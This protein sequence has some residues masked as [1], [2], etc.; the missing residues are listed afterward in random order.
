MNILAIDTSM[1]AC[2]VA[3]SARD[4]APRICA[5]YEKI[6]RGHA[7]RLPGMVDDVLKKAGLTIGQI[8]RFAVTRGPGTF[9][10]VRIGIAM[11]RGL[12]LGCNKPLVGI[13]TLQVLA[14][15]VLHKTPDLVSQKHQTDK[16]RLGIAIDA[17]RGEI[18][19]QRF[20]LSGEPLEEPL[21]LSPQTVADALKSGGDTVI[22]A[23][24]GAALITPLLGEM[25]LPP[26]LCPDL[27]PRA[28]RLVEIAARITASDIASPQS[29][30]PLYLRP[31]DAKVQTGH[32]IE[33]Q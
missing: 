28:E 22:L 2:S 27:Q 16:P 30:R 20:D 32:A 14:A 6:G 7:E 1:Q 17:R 18:Y 21:A 23:G 5:V 19:W 11:A 33:R 8:G 31:A 10:G 29:T 24:S 13:G 3:V 15:Q 25:S 9:T 26:P 4:G 12:A